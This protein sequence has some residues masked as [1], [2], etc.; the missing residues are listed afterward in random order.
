MTGEV[1]PN[2]EVGIIDNPPY[3]SW[4]QQAQCAR[5][6][7]ALLWTGLGRKTPH[8]VRPLLFFVSIIVSLLLLSEIVPIQNITTT[9]T[10]S[11]DSQ[12]IAGLMTDAQ[13]SLDAFQSTGTEKARNEAH[14]KALRLARAL[15][16][17]RDAILKLSFSV[18]SLQF[19]LPKESTSLITAFIAYCHHGSQG[20]ARL[21]HL[22]R[23]RR[24]DITG[25]VGQVGSSW[26][27]GGSLVSRLVILVILSESHSYYSC[28]ITNQN[29]EH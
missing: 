29:N 17:P 7:I 3:S 28:A 2:G 26:K 16:Q 27:T 23:T 22:L 14:D 10:T 9:R 21:E 25:A 8:V 1:Y 13:T 11:M 12:L 24:G 15:E 20:G 4:P 6:I 19:Q 18:G 5:E